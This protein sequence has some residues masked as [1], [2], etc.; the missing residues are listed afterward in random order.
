ME[1]FIDI[2][3]YEGLYKINRLGQVYSVYMDEIICKNSIVRIKKEISRLQ[4]ADQ[5]AAAKAA[6]A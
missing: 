1:D 5:E 2:I 4:T 6:E 3:G